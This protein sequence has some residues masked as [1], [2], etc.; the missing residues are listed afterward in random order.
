MRP[1]PAPPSSAPAGRPARPRLR[2]RSRRETSHA[3]G[4]PSP[5]ACRRCATRLK[6][7]HG[8]A[9]R[10]GSN[11]RPPTSGQR[12]MV[13]GRLATQVILHAAE[14]RVQ[15][16][17][18]RQDQRLQTPRDAPVG[19]GKRPDHRDVQVRQRRAHHDRHAGIPLAEQLEQLV[20]PAPA[21]GRRPAPRTRFRRYEHRARRPAP[22]ARPPNGCDGSPRSITKWRPRSRFASKRRCG[23]PGQ[24]QDIAQ[25]VAVVDDGR[26]IAAPWAPNGY[27]MVRRRPARP[28]R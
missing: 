14:R 15:H 20:R 17:R 16:A 26:P 1:P 10:F 21:R 19:V 7:T 3:A 18:T 22:A 5:P 27:R 9:L 13:C 6:C 11:A 8:R 28:G 24:A 12:R 2:P 23:S 4:Q 25:R